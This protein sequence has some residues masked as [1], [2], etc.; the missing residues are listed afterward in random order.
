M[1]E[2]PISYLMCRHEGYLKKSVNWELV[3][4]N[5]KGLNWD[6]IIRSSCPVS[7]LNEALLHVIR[8][9]FQA[10]ECV[11][12]PWFNDRCAFAHSLK[13]RACSCS[14]TQTDWVEY[15]GTL[16]RAQLVYED[17]ELAF[18]WRGASYLQN[19]WSTVYHDGNRWCEL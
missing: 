3:I 4:G 11:D 15:W 18:L 9:S 5:L 10:D 1:L 13:Q 17:A 2:Q 14:R 19:W 16:C 7:F 8:D 12:N 6:R